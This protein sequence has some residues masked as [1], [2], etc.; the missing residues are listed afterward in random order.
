MGKPRGWGMHEVEQA[1]KERLLSFWYF[2]CQVWS[3]KMS[4]GSQPQLPGLL[5]SRRPRPLL[6]HTG[7]EN[8]RKDCQSLQELVRSVEGVG[9]GWGVSRHEFH[10]S[11]YQLAL[12]LSS[13]FM[14]CPPGSCVWTAV[15]LVVLFWELVNLPG[16]ADSLKTGAWGF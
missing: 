5:S 2:L 7:R 10:R 4:S 3:S 1:I 13:L 15:E 9:L 12:A 11:R 6:G 14:N 16:A 8:S